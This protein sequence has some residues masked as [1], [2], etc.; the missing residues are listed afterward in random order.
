MWWIHIVFMCLCMCVCWKFISEKWSSGVSVGL[1]FCSKYFLSTS[2]MYHLCLNLL[3]SSVQM[4]C[5]LAFH[6][7][8][9]DL[10]HWPVKETFTCLLSDIFWNCTTETSTPLLQT[11]ILIALSLDSFLG[12][13]SAVESIAGSCCLMK[14]VL[15]PHCISAQPASITLF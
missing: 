10:P 9:T 7:S 15:G 6:Q 3:F 5:Q 2:S 8:K 13:L 14:E 11:C 1:F 12:H 4:F